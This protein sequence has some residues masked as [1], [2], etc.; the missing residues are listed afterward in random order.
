MLN[1]S[2]KAL[3]SLQPALLTAGLAWL[4]RA[5][6]G[7][8]QPD[9]WSPR[10]PLDYAAVVGTS[11][12]L[13]LTALG[14]WVFY[15]QHPAPPSRA[16]AVWRAGIGVI[17]TSALAIG[18][19]NFIEDALKVKGLGLVWV[20]GILALL[21]GLLM[22]GVSVFW[23]RGFSR[24]VGVLFLVCAAGLLFTETNGQF[25]LGLALMGLSAMQ[26]TQQ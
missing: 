12:A 26:G 24:W 23:M 13:V 6:I 2:L 8:Y 10:T 20:I 9:Y 14:V 17:C 16:Q 3:R 11:T 19:S 5:V 1:I 4:A 25:G 22:A 18:V 21:V 15:Q 7:L